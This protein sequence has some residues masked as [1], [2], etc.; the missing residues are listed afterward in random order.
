[1]KR[2]NVAIVGCGWVADWHA[3]DGLAHLPELFALTRVPRHRRDEDATRS[4]QRYGIAQRDRRASPTCWRVR[5]S[6]SS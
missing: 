3:R 2:L 4:Q 5:I 6:T 1:M